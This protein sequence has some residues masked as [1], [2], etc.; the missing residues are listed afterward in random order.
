MNM[1]YLHKISQN[2]FFCLNSEALL[3]VFDLLLDHVLGLDAESL[4]SLLLLP[5]IVLEFL[6]RIN[7]CCCSTSAEVFTALS[8]SDSSE[9]LLLL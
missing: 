5:F 6:V 7:R 9:L 4:R 2:A 1:V 8:E 3:S